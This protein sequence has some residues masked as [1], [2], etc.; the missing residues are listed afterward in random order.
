MV[1]DFFARHSDC[2][3]AIF[4]TN[5]ANPLVRDRV[6][7]VNARLRNQAGESRLLVHRRCKNLIEDLERVHWKTD[8]QGNGSN[9]IDKSDPAR[10]HAS[11]A[12]GYMLASLFPMQGKCGFYRERLL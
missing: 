2:F 9:D 1:R 4:H 5:T 3:R 7:C 8:A 12:L 11:D 6:N 10:T